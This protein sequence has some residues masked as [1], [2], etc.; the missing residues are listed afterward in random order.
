MF[1]RHDG[2]V[3]PCINVAIG[4]PS[5]FLGRDV[6]IPNVH[7][8]RLPEQDLME[9]WENR[10]CRLYREN[11]AR[12]VKAFDDTVMQNLVGGSSSRQIALQKA[13]DAMPAPPDGCEICHYLYD[14]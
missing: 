9:L 6:I 13:H 14:I 10:T 12:R 1:V 2:R 5:T 11:F 4:G 8:G 7:Y 3:S